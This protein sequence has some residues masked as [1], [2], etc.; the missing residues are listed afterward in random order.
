MMDEWLTRALEFRADRGCP[1]SHTLGR[2]LGLIG[3]K[4]IGDGHLPLAER[5][6]A[7]CLGLQNTLLAPI[8]SGSS[9]PK[10]DDCHAVI[11]S[12]D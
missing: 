6:A 8:G 11:Q 9:T 5:R 1:S 10:F 2:A 12:V 3:D 7:L 4:N